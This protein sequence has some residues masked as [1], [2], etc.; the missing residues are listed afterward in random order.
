MGC[1][2]FV[3]LNPSVSIQYTELEKFLCEETKAV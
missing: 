2:Y 1:F 3:G